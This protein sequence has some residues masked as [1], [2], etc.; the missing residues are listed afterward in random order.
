MRYVAEIL[1]IVESNKYKGYTV[2]DFKEKFEVETSKEFTNLMKAL[3]MLE[4]EYMLIRDD[5]NRYFTLKSLNYIVGTLSI[6]AKG[7]GFVENEDISVYANKNET[8]KALDQDE[9]LAKVIHNKD[10]SVEC[11]IVRIVHHRKN[12]IVGVIKKERNEHGFY[13]IRLCQIESLRLQ[14]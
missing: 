10:G 1:D 6:H 13:Q 3:N 4:N 11:E 2:E 7:F 8:L 12:T 14:I 9:V 5:K